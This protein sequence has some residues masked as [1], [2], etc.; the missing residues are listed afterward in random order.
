LL[1]ESADEIERLRNL[2]RQTS[3]VAGMGRR[4]EACEMLHAEVY[5]DHDKEAPAAP[6]RPHELPGL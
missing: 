6:F 1:L 3:E 5:P 4:K 2:I